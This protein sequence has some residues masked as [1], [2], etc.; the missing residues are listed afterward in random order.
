[1]TSATWDVPIGRER[2]VQLPSVLGAVL[3]DWS[4]TG[5]V[6]L[7]SGVPV[8]VTQTT[9]NN[10]FAGFGTQRPNVNGARWP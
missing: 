10:A 4:V 6:T 9:N 8:A 2:R 1:M 3:D 7:Q 5:V